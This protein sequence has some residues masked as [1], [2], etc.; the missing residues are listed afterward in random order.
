MRIRDLAHGYRVHLRATTRNMFPSHPLLRRNSRFKDIHKGER[1][2]ILGSGP[3]IA[4]QDLTR[5]HGEIVITQNHFH[6]HPDISVIHPKY[7]CVVPMYQPPQYNP[8]WV[9]WFQTMEGR[10][11]GNTEIFMGLNSKVL[12]DE[13][14]LLLDRR[15]YLRCELNP[16]FMRRAVIDITRIVMAVPT[17]L[18]ECLTV[19]LYMGFDK[20]YLLGFDLDQVCRMKD[21]TKVRFY[22]LSPITNNEAEKNFER[23]DIKSGWE[24]FNFWLIWKQ[25]NLLGEE[26]ARNGQTI[27]NCTDGGLLDCFERQ[28]Y[29]EVI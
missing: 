20:I 18:T 1:C 11:P 25:L 24:W 17:V 6:A 10:L 28:N 15:S 23:R 12:V 4:R 7:H 27:I 3:S 21:R 9:R 13:N 22:G 19:A 5:L 16:M 2:F 29:E 8:D 26:A 14:R